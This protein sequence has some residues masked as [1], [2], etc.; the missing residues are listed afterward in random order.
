MSHVNRGAGPPTAEL[1]PGEA[2]VRELL[3]GA[4]PRPEVPPEK[5]ARI[6]AAARA[7]WERLPKSSPRSAPWLGRAIPLALAAGV[8]VAVS[9]A[10]WVGREA[11]PKPVSTPVPIATVELV[12]GDAVG[13]LAENESAPLTRGATLA[14]GSIVATSSGPR[15]GLVAMRLADGGA[16]RL[17]V[18]TRIRLSSRN[19]IA[20]EAGAVYLDSD[21]VG[22]EA[23]PVEIVT[24]LGRV[25]EIGTRFVVRVGESSENGLE[26]RVR[27]GRIALDDGRAEHAVAA[28]EGLRLHRDGTTERQPIELYGPEWDWI[29]SA[30]PAPEIENR[31]LSAFLEWLARET[32]WRVRFE[33]PELAA[34]AATIRLHGTIEGLNPA[35]AAEV[36]LSGAGLQHRLEAGTVVVSR[37]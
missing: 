5:M 26:V 14:A 32:G 19:Q 9:I 30:A 37:P 24:L 13:A 10:W 31:T 12:R 35:E 7:E 4:G 17:D 1:D 22:A 16:L 21:A 3:E 28:G 2:E 23:P 33:D 6:R 34:S 36:V 8:L 18:G 15:A 11:T 25:R 29:R 20:L 27:D